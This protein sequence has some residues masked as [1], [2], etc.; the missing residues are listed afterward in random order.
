MFDF[1]VCAVTNLF[2]IYLVYRFA[3]VFLGKKIE[4]R[5]K[6]V[7]VY[8]CF[9]IANTGL[10]WGFH[11]AWINITCNLVGISAIVRLHTKSFKTNLFV[12]SIIYLINM[13]CD[14]A[15]TLLFI[16]Y[17]DG[18][19]HSQVYAAISVFM[20]FICELLTEKLITNRK[21]MENTPNSPLII[22]P[23]SSIIVICLLIYSNSC[24]E[25]GI[26]IV[27][28]GL[29]VVNFYM[30]YLYNLLLHFISQKYEAERLRQKMQIYA[31]QLDIILQS[32]EK[33]KA[34]K[35]DI[36]HHMNEIKLLAQKEKITEINEYIDQMEEFM[37][38]PKELVASGNTEIDSLLNYML[39]RAK[40]ELKTVCVKVL[41]PEDI[42]HSFDVNVLLGNLLENAI[43]AAVQTERKYLSVNIILSKGTLDI[44]IENS[45]V[46]VNEIQK[47]GHRTFLTT[48]KEKEW[49]GIGLNNV[50]KI[51]ESYN[52]AM[53]ID[54]RDDIFSV[55]LILYMTKLK[56][57]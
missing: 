56:N 28:I 41:L 9:F 34:L 26:A 7:L 2:R 45:F 53:K 52:G 50:K 54:T 14:V 30:L 33:V 23:L 57:D 48:K 12:T 21:H 55:R 44:L 39:Q 35:H 49:H 22:V 20:I 18:Q 17:H 3:E 19:I 42:K 15:G 29:L 13:G 46:G 25:M 24:E 40:E 5:H 38:N 27:S 37:H 8:L 16:S 1:T 10:F 31:N 47:D 36:K 43:E 32:E 11:T 6:A 51:V 4:E